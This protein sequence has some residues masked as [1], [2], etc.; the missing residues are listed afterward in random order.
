M[1]AGLGI[2]RQRETGVVDRKLTRRT[3]STFTVDAAHFVTRHGVAGKS[4]VGVARAGQRRS[5]QLDAVA[6]EVDADMLGARLPGNPRNAVEADDHVG[7]HHA[8]HVR[9]IDASLESASLRLMSAAA[10]R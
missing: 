3:L 6:V 5:V 8:G 10:T 7:A 9:S 1:T 2:D 4:V